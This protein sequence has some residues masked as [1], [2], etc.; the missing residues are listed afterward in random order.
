MHELSIAQNILDIVRDYVTEERYGEVQA[1]K[2]RLGELSGVQAESLDF[3]FSAIVGETALK[4]AALKIEHVPPRLHCA[5]CG[6]SCAADG[7]LCRCPG[8]GDRNVKLVSGTE[9]Q[10][11]EIELADM[12]SE[13]L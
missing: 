3:C 10:V 6:N 4:H 9:L 11:T 1:V 2:V 7:L 5:A 12:P 13:A 8:C